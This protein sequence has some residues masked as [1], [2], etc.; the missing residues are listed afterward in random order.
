MCRK[1][2]EADPGI[3]EDRKEPPEMLFNLA[4]M[5]RSLSPC[6]LSSQNYLN[7]SHSALLYLFPS[8]SFSTTAKESEDNAPTKTKKPIALPSLSSGLYSLPNATCIDQVRLNPTKDY[9]ESQEMVI[10]I[11]LP[12]PQSC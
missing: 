1:G 12:S 6:D 3:A 2:Q 7:P 9:P 10:I 8:M 4:E 5:M 11:A